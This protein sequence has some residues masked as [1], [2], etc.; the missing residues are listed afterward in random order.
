M[1]SIAIRITTENEEKESEM[2]ALAIQNLNEQQK[3]LSIL[4]HDN[5]DSYVS[6]FVA[7]RGQYSTTN[8]MDLEEY[9]QVHNTYVSVHSF[10]KYGR[11]S[12]DIRQINAIYFD[13]DMH[14]KDILNKFRTAEEK[15]D[16]IDECVGNTLNLLYD[17][18]LQEDIPEPTM[19]TNTG[20][21]LGIFY[22]LD[23]SIA[24]AKG[25]NE[26]QV[27]YWK[28]IYIGLALKFKEILNEDNNEFAKHPEAILEFD[29]KVVADVSRVTRMPMT[30]NQAVKRPCRLVSA[31]GTYYS[32]KE[33]SRYIKF[34]PEKMIHKK[35]NVVQVD[36][37]AMRFHHERMVAMEN[38][39]KIRHYDCNGNREYM[40]FCYYNEA[41]QLYG[42]KQASL[43]VDAY[44]QKFTE[45]LNASEIKNM[46]KGVDNNKGKN[47]AGYYK[48]TNRWI[49]ENCKITPAEQE[50]IGINLTKRQ[51][52][53]QIIKEKHQKER[54]ERNLAIISYA[55]NHVDC[56]YKA[57]AEH[58][59]VSLSTIKN[60]LKMGKI[61]RYNKEEKKEKTVQKKEYDQTKEK[62]E[63]FQIVEE[64]KKTK[65][66]PIVCCGT[67][68]AAVTGF[69][70]SFYDM[71]RYALWQEDV[72]ELHYHFQ[73]IIENKHLYLQ[74]KEKVIDIGIVSEL[75]MFYYQNVEG[76]VHN[77]TMG[78]QDKIYLLQF[79]VENR[80][81]YF[82][83]M[84]EWDW[85]KS[86]CIE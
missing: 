6:R 41:V 3:F 11:K 60:V 57:I 27:M 19:I 50:S 61:R 68:A 82:L 81:V 69:I 4:H 80:E 63:K 44:N 58:F 2:S 67:Q 9:N 75:E 18:V 16:F 84:S 66:C 56:P 85:R 13:L 74:Q 46:I 83:N 14:N 70:S 47:H 32:L 26:K 40:C 52:D 39:P 38:L 79:K 23:R 48:L 78:K 29:D 10:T 34:V 21:G 59:G 86:I 35:D 55:Q 15:L 8:L 22:V 30:Y 5:R 12:E 64:I 54:E 45:P 72:Q 20:R 49:V 76:N 73:F 43:M 33:L 65:K 71:H 77:V 36:F 62:K 7:T 31:D 51:I 1:S 42:T 53:R 17:A 37:Y 25:K 28:Q 24:C